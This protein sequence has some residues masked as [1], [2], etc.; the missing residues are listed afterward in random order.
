MTPTL[1]INYSVIMGENDLKYTF[2]ALGIL[3]Y[4]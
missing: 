2:A 1:L 4:V 3:N